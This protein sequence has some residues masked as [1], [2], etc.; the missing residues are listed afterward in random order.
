V[1]TSDIPDD[2]PASRDVLVSGRTVLVAVI[3]RSSCIQSCTQIGRVFLIL[4]PTLTQA[5]VDSTRLNPSKKSDNPELIAP[6]P[7]V[8]QELV[9]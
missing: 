9:C 2:A 4:R 5:Y 7:L 1:S 6:V 3:L 8:S